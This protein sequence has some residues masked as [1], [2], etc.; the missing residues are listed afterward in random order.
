MLQRKAIIEKR[1]ATLLLAMSAEELVPQ[2]HIV[3]LRESL[4]AHHGRPAYLQ[5]NTIGELVTENLESIRL[6]LAT[7]SSIETPESGEIE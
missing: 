6:N 7:P 1:L 2:A 5:C 3:E 4:A